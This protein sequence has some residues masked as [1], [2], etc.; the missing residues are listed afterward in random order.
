MSKN[1]L[2]KR[3]QRSELKN[4]LLLATLS[5]QG[6]TGRY[7]LKNILNLSEREGVVRMMLNDLKCGGYIDVNK[8]GCELTEKGKTLLEKYRIIAIKDVDLEVLG[9]RHRCLAIHIRGPVTK[10]I[11]E[12]RD[13]A[14]RAGADG[15][16]LICNEEGRLKIPTVYDD[17][18]VKFPEM[19]GQLREA[20]NLS[21]G[22]ILLVGFSEDRWRALEGALAATMK[23]NQNSF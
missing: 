22:D 14:V 15:A 12:L 21:T 6:R 20:F 18:D 1:K 19:A 7:R 23:I 16:I 10:K 4:L 8:A 5:L 17:L 13:T 11:I 2:G 9:L 3:R